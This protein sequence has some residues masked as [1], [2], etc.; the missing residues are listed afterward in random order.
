MISR[1]RTWSTALPIRYNTVQTTTDKIGSKGEIP[2][3][4]KYVNILEGGD[5]VPGERQSEVPEVAS[6]GGA[7]A[8]KWPR[9]LFWALAAILAAVPAR[10][11]TDKPAGADEQSNLPKW[12]VTC[13][14]GNA[15]GAFRCAMQQTL[16]LSSTKQR[17]L[18]FT[19]E[20]SGSGFV[21]TLL[22]PHGIDLTKGVRFQ[23]D[24]AAEKTAKIGFADQN[25]SYASFALDAQL[26]QAMRK[27]SIFRVKTA[28]RSGDDLVIELS[29]SG[30]STSLAILERN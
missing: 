11:Q 21:G 24:D 29:L 8:R 17:I 10:A 16:Y 6:P 5:G 23:T 28:P 27:G 4:M 2:A 7:F 26:L 12:V 18:A 1:A 22:L 20:K 14:N 25:G 3:G 15:E 30:F 9:P 13:G 19:V